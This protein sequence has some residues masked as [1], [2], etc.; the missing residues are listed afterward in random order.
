VSETASS[1]APVWDRVLTRLWARSRFTSYFYQFCDLAEAPHLPTLAL[2]VSRRRFRLFYNPGFVLRTAPEHLIGLLVHEMLHVVLNHRHRAIP[3]RDTALQNLAQ[4]MVINSYLLD[5]RKTFFARR[6]FPE[7]PA[8]TLP[9]GLPRIPERFYRETG[10][11]RGRDVSWEQL[12]AWLA[13][14]RAAGGLDGA[15]DPEPDP[16][17]PPLPDTSPWCDPGRRGD[18]AASPDGLLFL[19]VAGE[20]LPTGVHLFAAEE[21]EEEARTGRRRILDFLADRTDCRGE[22]VLAD[23]SALLRDAPVARRA[24]KARILGIVD[25]SSP[26]VRWD[27][28]YARPNRRWFQAGVYAPGRVYTPRRLVTVAADVSGSMTARPDRVEAA[29]GIVEALAERYR[30]S[31]VCVDQQLFVPQKRENAFTASGGRR[32]YFYRKGDWRCIRTGSRGAT[33][34]APLFNDYMKGHR[35]V[36]VVLTDG[37]IYD[38]DSLAPYRPT[39]WAVPRGRLGAFLPPFGRVVPMEPGT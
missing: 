12:Y 3:G 31:L 26:S 39:L 33:F 20:P 28:S 32:P 11:A 10:R 1:P 14:R 30:V 4:D 36:L 7:C 19:D 21:A 25:R 15:A 9:P 37:Q 22:R 35:E 5:N 38:L 16:G 27:P 17:A 18:P 2:G 23:L 13:G 24:W 6:E 29:F 34:F 8:L